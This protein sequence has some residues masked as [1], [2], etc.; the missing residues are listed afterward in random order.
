MGSKFDQV[1]GDPD[2][3]R[4]ESAFPL[5]NPGDEVVGRVL[6][7]WTEKGKFANP[8]G[9][10]PD[11]PYVELGDVEYNGKPYTGTLEVR[12]Y[13]AGRAR[14][15]GSAEVG[16]MLAIRYDG[17]AAPGGPHAYTGKAVPPRANS[18]LPTADP[19]PAAPSTN[20]TLPF[21]ASVA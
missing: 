18:D 12:G 16:D 4:P 11:V 2:G 21:A 13:H 19:G 1:M 10:Y 15:I 14:I 5:S 6:K 9:E 7:V 3:R 17:Q 8:N 20:E